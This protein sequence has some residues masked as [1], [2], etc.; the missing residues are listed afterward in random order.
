M[1]LYATVAKKPDS[2][3][4]TLIIMGV[5]SFIV[6]VLLPRIKGPVEVGTAGVKAAVE[7]VA[8]IDAMRT[9]AAATA[10][11]VAQA[12][13]DEQ[14]DKEAKVARQ[15]QV[16]LDTVTIWMRLGQP[17]SQLLSK[18]RHPSRSQLLSESEP[19]LLDTYDRFIEALTEFSEREP[20]S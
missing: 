6:G 1:V 8:S 4:I 18:L 17:T 19:E 15:V 20:K 9:I 3:L 16:L 12:T 13:I 10:E 7:G 2:V 5:G 14:P 11:T